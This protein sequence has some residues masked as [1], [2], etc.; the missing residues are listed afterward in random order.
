M[1]SWEATLRGLTHVRSK[2][3]P[4]NRRFCLP[5]WGHPHTIQP[6]GLR[7]SQDGSVAFVAL[8][9]ANHVAVVD[10][11]SFAVLD[12]ILVGQRPW[13]I[14]RSVDGSRIYV[15]NGL[16]NDMTIIDV[17][18]RKALKSVPVGRLPWGI[19]GSGTAG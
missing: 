17:A 16:S 4:T 2:T 3:P 1:A 5:N 10:T 12:Y 6:V 7:F 9:L 11:D 13:H 19:A 8:G 18:S 14:E 15:A